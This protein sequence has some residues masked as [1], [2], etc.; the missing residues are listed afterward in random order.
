MALQ[1]AVLYDLFEIGDGL[2]VWSAHLYRTAVEAFNDLKNLIDGCDELR[3]DVKSISTAKGDEAV[4]LLSGARLEFAARSR[5]SGRGLSGDKVI[6][7]E[8]FELNPGQ[9]G[10]LVPIM[11]AR[12]NPQLRY[13]SSAGML[14]SD[15]LRAVRDRG[16]KPGEKRLAYL[17]WCCPEQPCASDSCAHVLG[18]DGCALDDVELLAQGNPA[19]G[20]RLSL[21]FITDVERRSLTPVEYGRERLGWWEDPPSGGGALDVEKWASLTAQPTPLSSPAFGA[22]LD[23]AGTGWFAVAWSRPEGVHVQLAGRSTASKLTERAAELTSKHGGRVFAGGPALK[24]LDNA[25]PVSAAEFA[26]GCRRV[27]DLLDSGGL[28]HSD[29]PELNASIAAVRWRSSSSDGSQSWQ[30]KDTPTVGPL[31]AA[32]RALCG[33]MAGSGGW[34]LVL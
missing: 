32:T 1:G 18:S 6:L 23:E 2:I 12:P 15:V 25:E 13:A 17:E 30:L 16:R 3:R 28:R 14:T 26:A 22:D 4:E 33:L 7:D 29:E 8:A 10:A 9:I 21:E 34:L 31:A 5:R 20:R 27:A 24:L 11:S 19:L